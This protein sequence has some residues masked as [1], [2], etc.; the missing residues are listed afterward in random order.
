[1]SNEQHKG[2]GPAPPAPA[3]DSLPASNRNLTLCPMFFVFCL[4]LSSCSSM[5]SAFVNEYNINETIA[6]EKNIPVFLENVLDKPYEYE[7]FIYERTP[8]HS[9]TKKTKL[10]RHLFYVFK[11]L[12]SGRYNTLGYFGTSFNFYSQGVWILNSNS[13][14]AAYEE[15]L[16]GKKNTWDMDLI[17]TPD[18]ID[19]VETVK[20]LIGK[21]TNRISYYYKDHLDD[22]QGV[23]N[24]NTAV[25][26][27]LVRKQF[28]DKT[29]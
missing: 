20:K 19:T 11:P 24:C 26:E 15:Y 18:N 5:Y 2:P 3:A 10:M 1:M 17:E 8:T 12:S 29:N 22:K 14:V 27:T 6:K 16:A 13:D 23:D 28:A 4:S 21:L 25:L 7:I 9:K